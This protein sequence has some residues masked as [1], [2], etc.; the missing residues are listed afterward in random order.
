MTRLALALLL[1]SAGLADAAPPPVGSEDY[2]LMAPF[3]DWITSQHSER[4]ISCC[5]LADGRPVDARIEGDHWIAHVTPEHFPGEIDHW[6]DIPE[7]KIVHEGNPMG[8][9]VLWLHTFGGATP[10]P[11]S[12]GI[13]LCFAPPSG[14]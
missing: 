2:R 12:G 11:A 1:A 9:P 13:V 4:G 10:G 8:V 14:V 6:V 5:S 7:D 3:K